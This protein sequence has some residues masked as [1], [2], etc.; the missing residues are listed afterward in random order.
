M[1]LLELSDTNQPLLRQLAEKAP[2]TFQHS[3]QVANLAEE[4]V[5]EING[6]VLLV[7]AGALYHDIGKL[8]APQF[9][10]ENQVSGINPHEGLTYHESVEIIVN[11]VYAGVEM[12]K[13]ANL[14]DQIIDFI[15]THH[16]TSKPEYFFRMY[17][18][19]NPN[20]IEADIAKQY[21][22]PGPKPFTKETAVLMMADAIEASSRSL[23]Q[24]TKM[25]LEEKINSIINFQMKEKQFDNANITFKEINKAKE[26]FLSKLQ[27]I[28]HARIEYPEENKKNANTK[29]NINEG[30]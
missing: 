4:V 11:H 19:E 9:F 13:K 20:A 16:G 17:M 12:A 14:P 18:Q 7:R 25:S 23:K 10:T 27:N 6:N 30:K 29:K 26:I 3:L 15:R 2:G 21:S 24:Y 8:S 5:R 1:T 28:Y 22:Y